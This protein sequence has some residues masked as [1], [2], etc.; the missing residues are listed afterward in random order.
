MTSM[1][2]PAVSPFSKS[3]VSDAYSSDRFATRLGRRARAASRN[4]EGG[5][6][7]PRRLGRRTAADAVVGGGQGLRIHWTQ[8]EGEPRRPV[9]GP[10]SADR[11]PR[12]LRARSVR[13]ARPC[14]PRLLARGRSRLEPRP[15]ERA[16]H[17][18]RLCL[19][20]AAGRHRPPQGADGLGGAV[21]HHHRQLRRRLRRRR[22]ARPQRLLPRRRQ[23]V[24]HLLHQQPRRRSDGDRLDFSTRRRSGARSYGRIR[25]RATPRP[26]PTNGGTGTTITKP[27]R[28]SIRDGSR[29]RT[30]GN[31]RSGTR[32][33]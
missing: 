13:L 29:C 26:R 31:P 28:P 16:R 4:G 9:R 2:L 23:G 8:R 7:G 3:E 20:R 1:A 27:R 10:P 33:G 32:R 25:P 18:A 15:S 6:P 11:L 14:L 30:P 19:P 22:V 24:P 5:V 17:D 21:V 12:L